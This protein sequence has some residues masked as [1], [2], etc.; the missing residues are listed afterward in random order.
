MSQA[1]KLLFGRALKKERHRKLMTMEALAKKA[2]TSKGYLSGIENGKVNPPF[3]MMVVRICVA[4]GISS[5]PLLLLSE[6]AKAAKAV[7]SSRSSDAR[8]GSKV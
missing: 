2:K 8:A 3:P 5:E 1:A 7:L 6:M 4:L